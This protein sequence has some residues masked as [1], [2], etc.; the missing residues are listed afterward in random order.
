MSPEQEKAWHLL[1]EVAKAAPKPMFFDPDRRACFHDFLIAPSVTYKT[2]M[3]AA[4]LV[5][6]G[7]PVLVKMNEGLPLVTILPPKPSLIA[8]LRAMFG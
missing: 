7:R 2:A 4:M 8:R 5:G 1:E 6:D 3:Q